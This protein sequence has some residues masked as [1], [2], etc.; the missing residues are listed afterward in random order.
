MAA[1]PRQTAL[2]TGASSGIGEAIA[3]RLAG[4]GMDLVLVARTHHALQALAE[5]LAQ[6]HK[7]RVTPLQADLSKPG[8]GEALRS[9][10]TSR[11]IA[12]DVLINNAGV[13]TYGLFERIA[14]QAERDEVAINVMAVVDLTHAFVPDMLR[15][16]RGVVLNIAS[17]AAFQPGPYMAVYSASKAFVLSFSEA[18]WAEYRERGVHVTALCPGAV[19]TGF[20]ARLGDPTVRQTRVFSSTHSVEKV[21]QDALLA[22]RGTAPSRIVGM[23]NWFLTQSSRFS[24]RAITA[25]ISGSLLQPPWLRQQGGVKSL[26]I[27]DEPG[28]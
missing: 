17:T 18:L 8:C 19:D 22:L 9:E 11:G 15:R 2:V 7:V 23:K 20:I 14:A 12:I 24:P 25:R 28:Q 10:I 6:Q 13:G 16:R 27:Q 26:L 21:A 1:T 4:E 3:R 5:T